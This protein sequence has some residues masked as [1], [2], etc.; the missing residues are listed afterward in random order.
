VYGR[1]TLNKI[2]RVNALHNARKTALASVC[3]SHDGIL[4]T[5]QQLCSNAF[6]LNLSIGQTIGNII[7]VPLKVHHS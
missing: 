5:Q 2:N 7:T 1:A 4:N 3:L 6:E